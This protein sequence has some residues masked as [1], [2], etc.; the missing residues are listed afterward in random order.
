MEKY[1]SL[2][3]LSE[4]WTDLL[5]SLKGYSFDEKIFLKFPIVFEQL[6]VYFII[7]HLWDMGYER[8]VKFS[9]ISTYFI[10]SLCQRKMEKT[11]NITVEDIAEISRMY[12]GEIEYSTENIGILLN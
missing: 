1:Y 7:R 4:D 12:S 2:E 11:G 5:D 6:A 8:A 3:R 9:Y 10:G